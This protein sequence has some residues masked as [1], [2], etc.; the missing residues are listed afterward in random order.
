MKRRSLYLCTVLISLS[1]PLLGAIPGNLEL[2]AL[3]EEANQA[4]L[5]VRDAKASRWPTVELELSGTYMSNPLIGPI[6]LPAGSLGPG[7]PPSNLSLFEGMESSMYDFSVNITQPLFTWGKINA[8]V[9]AQEA[10]AEAKLQE[11]QNREKELHAEISTR[12]VIITELEAITQLLKQQHTLGREL[13]L[14]ASEAV[15]SGM[16]LELEQLETEVALQDIELAILENEYAIT[17]QTLTLRTLTHN[18]DI[19]SYTF[20]GQAIKELLQLPVK[21]LIEYALSPRQPSIRALSALK[22]AT[23]AAVRI[24]KGSFYGKPDLALVMSAGYSSPNFPVSESD[25]SNQDAYSISVSVGLK[26][27]LFDG[28]KI[29]NSI[30]RAESQE[31]SATL[32]LQQARQRITQEVQEQYLLMKTSMQKIDLQE[33]KQ[34]TLQQRVRTNK[35]LYQSGYGT[36]EDLL[37]AEMN[38]LSSQIHEHQLN[39]EAWS[40]FQ[41]LQYLTGN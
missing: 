26:T 25:W 3:Q 12:A 40:A 19:S 23:E 11:L 36:R 4:I 7:T 33:R 10:I 5:D 37:Q 39:I 17:E 9:D 29:A 28:G 35:E 8:S 15:A 6:T 30:K 14:L 38:L 34:T 18:Q 1:F 21:T 32:D 2:A 24:T 16:M 20:D 22:K 31:Q 27:T 41:T 13:V